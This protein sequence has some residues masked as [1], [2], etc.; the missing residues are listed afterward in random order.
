MRIIS[1]RGEAWE[2]GGLQALGAVSRPLF[3]PSPSLTPSRHF[4]QP[5]ASRRYRSTFSA[6]ASLSCVAQ[7]RSIPPRSRVPAVPHR[8][9][10]AEN[11][12]LGGA[13]SPA[14]GSASLS[15]LVFV[16]RQFRPFLK[17]AGPAQKASSLGGSQAAP[18][19]PQQAL[20]RARN[21]LV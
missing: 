1:G 10:W 8:F 15:E 13:W 9:C 21:Q 6:T 3:P 16:L 7:D 2:F 19:P 17:L 12:A 20:G 11:W 4:F 14:P 18:A 5:D